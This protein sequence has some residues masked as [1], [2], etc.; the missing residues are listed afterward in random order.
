[1][2]EINIYRYRVVE[3]RIT[4]VE[5]AAEDMTEAEELIKYRIREGFIDMERCDEWD[6][7]FEKIITKPTGVY[8]NG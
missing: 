6:H 1:M 5:V 3:T 8:I 7:K 4:E 2:S